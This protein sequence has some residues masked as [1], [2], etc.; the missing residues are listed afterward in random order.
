[1]KVK[2]SK[3]NPEWT[4]LFQK[5]KK[6]ISDKLGDKI[7]TVEHIGS[8][9]VPGLGAKP[10]VD[11]QLGVRKISDA[12]KF[13]PKMEE[14]GYEYRNNFENVMP[15]RRYFTKP[16]HYHVHTVE[17]TSEFWRRHLLFRDYMRGHDDVRDAYFKTKK[18]LA[19]KEWDDTNDYAYAKSDFVR[20]IEKDALRHF[21]LLT[22][23]AESDALFEMY[24]GASNETKKKC[25]IHTKRIGT[26]TLIRTDIFPGFSHNR[27]TGLG[28]D[29]LLRDSTIIIVKSFYSTIK[30]K[31]AL[32]LN[33]LELTVDVKEL[34][35]KFGYEHKN[36]WV[37]F[38][39]DTAPLENV[40]TGLGIKS[41]GNE[42]VNEYSSLITT[43]F[44]FPAELNALFE[45]VMENKSWKHYMA[46]DGSTPVSTGSV[47][48]SGDTA[49]IGFAATNPEYRGR[50][51]QGA[52][53]KARI[54]EAR[55]R[56][57]KWI[58]VETAEDTSEHDAPSYRNMLRYGFRL[59]YKRPN[60][61]FEP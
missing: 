23:K 19:E 33:P 6:L 24:S 44:G 59:L 43:T 15:Y 9:A 13:I 47:Y 46:F 8:T 32:Q 4:T 55:N 52:I 45:P 36:N 35:Q 30:N 27:V 7:V 22:E 3:Y 40:K 21:A 39:R 41:V 28:L 20:K 34:L 48:F 14:I 37:R 58:A 25:G 12:D 57:C 17:V 56:G 60:Y 54:N 29:Y 11:I 50:G 42:F 51:A 53:L 38:Y 26:A 49:W 16:G 2:L 61:V 18:E 5:E 10:I 31:H 1:M